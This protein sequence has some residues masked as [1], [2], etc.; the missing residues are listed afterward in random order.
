MKAKVKVAIINGVFAIICA[1]IT[2]WSV[3]EQKECKE[4]NNEASIKIYNYVNANNNEGNV[5]E[6]RTGQKGKW[7]RSGEWLPDKKRK[8]SAEQSRIHPICTI[9]QGS[10]LLLLGVCTGKK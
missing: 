1:G 10:C 8:E 9:A 5:A 7:Q 2:V 3:I 4:V 6:V